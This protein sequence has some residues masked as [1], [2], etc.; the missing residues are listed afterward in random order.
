[1]YTCTVLSQSDGSCDSES[2]HTFDTFEIAFDFYMSNNIGIVYYKLVP[3]A[4]D[5]V[6]NMIPCD[7]MEYDYWDDVTC[8]YPE[9]VSD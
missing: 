4:T 5:G 3:D 1:M 9:R 8:T 2:D 7:V 6:A